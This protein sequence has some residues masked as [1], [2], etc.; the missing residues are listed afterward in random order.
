MQHKSNLVTK[1]QVAHN[2][3]EIL[4]GDLAT[5]LADL[6]EESLA[7]AIERVLADPPEIRPE[8]YERF[9]VARIADRYLALEL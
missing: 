7:A 1:L 4:T 9:G 6:T 5:G 2:A 3:V 8:H